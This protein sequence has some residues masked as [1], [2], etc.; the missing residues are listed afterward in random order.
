[1]RHQSHATPLDDTD[2]ADELDGLLNGLD[3]RHSQASQQLFH[4]L[5]D[6]APHLD[7]ERYRK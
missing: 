4:R 2:V 6:I 7:S 5:P 3:P 1:L